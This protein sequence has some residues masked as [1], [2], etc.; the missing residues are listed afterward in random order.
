MKKILVLP[1]LLLSSVITSLAQGPTMISDIT[2]TYNVVVQNAKVDT[3]VTKALSGTTKI[4]YIKGAKSR[5]ELETPNFK[6][7]IIYDSKTDSTV[8]LRELG[9][10]KYISYLDGNKRKEK[11]TKYEGI[12]FTKTAEKKT[13]LGYECD[14]VIAK[15]ADGS[16]YDVYYTNSVVP[17]TTEYEYQFKDLPGLVLEYEAEFEQGKIK[18]KYS[19]SKIALLPVPEVKF[20]TPKSGYRVL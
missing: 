6:Q 5:I 9:N 19:A 3:A 1:T 7:T 20:D 17:S 13:L 16:T 11:N 8:I 18:V 2:L 15:L 10:T 14:K 12:K 4:L